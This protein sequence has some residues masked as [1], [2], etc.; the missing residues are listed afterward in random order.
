MDNTIFGY[1][2][3]DAALLDEALTTPSYRMADGNAR[4]NQRLEFLGDSVLNMLAA[5]CVYKELPDAQEG[6]LTIARTHMV[7]T[8]ALCAAAK[9]ENLMPRLK[10]SKGAQGV[11]ENS[12]VL[13]DAIEAIFGAAWLDGGI[14]AAKALFKHLKLSDFSQQGEWSRNPKGDLQIRAQAMEPARN[15][16]YETLSR[17]GKP[18]CPDVYCK[19]SV[20]GV[21][22]AEATAH[23]RKAAETAAAEKMLALMDAMGLDEKSLLAAR[24]ESKLA[25]ALRAVEGKIKLDS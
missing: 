6:K 17:G 18:H 14:D 21:G 7:S 23:S 5:S 3:T 25:K 22:S 4:D 11:S 10:F 9:R 1:T 19:V 2:F 13:A 24:K 20:D 15:A 12:K 8:L 16:H